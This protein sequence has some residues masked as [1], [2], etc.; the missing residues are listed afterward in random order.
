MTANCH[1]L[2][3]WLTCGDNLEGAGLFLHSDGVLSQA[4]QIS[5][6]FRCFGQKF[7]LWLEAAL[8]E[9]PMVLP[10]L[11]FTVVKEPPEA[12]S[13][14][15]GRHLNRRHH[16]TDNPPPPPPPSLCLSSGEIQGFEIW[17]VG[18]KL[19]SGVCVYSSPSECR[20]SRSSNLSYSKYLL[21]S[22]YI[23]S[24]QKISVWQEKTKIENCILLLCTP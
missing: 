20:S 5:I 17:L 15:V 6:V 23:Q 21:S 24:C 9:V 4:K 10:L 16:Q 12:D 22:I 7:N 18:S 1:S 13:G 2:T 19:E 3:V 11:V 14:R 8:G